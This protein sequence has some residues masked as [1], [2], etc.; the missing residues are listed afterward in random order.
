MSD[1]TP[2]DGEFGLDY[3]VYIMRQ[4]I[5]QLP[6]NLA[7]HFDGQLNSI[8]DAVKNRFEIV[9]SNITDNLDDAT[10]AI[11]MLEFDLQA[12]KKERDDLQER[13]DDSF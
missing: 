12:T 2:I 5:K 7:E 10:L 13:L 9:K 4:M 1:N 8:I 11:K 3:Q 6:P